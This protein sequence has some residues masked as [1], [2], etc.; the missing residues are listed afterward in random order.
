MFTPGH[1]RK[2]EILNKLYY[3]VKK[4]NEK[5][6]KKIIVRSSDIQKKNR[7]KSKIDTHNTPLHVRS[8]PWLATYC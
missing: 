6:G 1:Y 7:R 5:N 3:D 2:Q 4:T 8:L